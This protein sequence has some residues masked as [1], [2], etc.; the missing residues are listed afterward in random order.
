MEQ[1]EKKPG[2]LQQVLQKLGRRHSVIADTLTRLQDRGIKLSQSRLYQIIADDGA[3]KEVAD[4]FLEVAEEEF[5]RRRQV[6]ERARQLI[7][8]A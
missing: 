3:R 5:A 2:V 4:T 7:N 8:E 6:Q 1:K